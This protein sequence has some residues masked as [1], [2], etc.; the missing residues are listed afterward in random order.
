M[1]HSRNYVIEFPLLI[2][3]LWRLPTGDGSASFIY[4]ITNGDVFR[5]GRSGEELIQEVSEEDMEGAAG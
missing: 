3:P 5:S 4:G 2:I 1:G